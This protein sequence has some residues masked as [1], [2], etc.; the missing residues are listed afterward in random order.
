MKTMFKKTLLAVALAGVGASAQAAVV[1]QSLAAQDYSKQ[2]VAAKAADAAVTATFSVQLKA[3]YKNDDVIT[4]KFTS[5]TKTGWTAPASVIAVPDDALTDAVVTLGL[6][7]QTSDTLTYRVTDVNKSAGNTTIDNTITFTG[8]EFTAATLLSVTDIKVTYS[9]KTATGNFEIDTGKD[10]TAKILAAVDQFK[11]T[12]SSKFDALIELPARTSLKAAPAPTS[13]ATTFANDVALR[14]FATI[15]AVTYT[16]E[17]D[18][19]WIKDTSD[20]DVGLTPAPTLFTGL[21][22]QCT[23]TV[24]TST[25]SKLVF[26]CTAGTPLSFTFNIAANTA[27]VGQPASTAT[28]ATVAQTLKSTKYALTARVAY[29]TPT[30]AFN[31]LSAADAGEWKV[32]GVYVDVPYLLAGTVGEKEFSYVVNVTNNHSLSGNVTLDVYKEDGSVVAT[33]VAAGS[34]APNAIKRLGTDI[35]VKDN[36]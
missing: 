34:V 26:S 20:A 16:L 12:I 31:T 10:N 18:F 7:S 24:A 6:L 9:A 22:A 30:G 32:D 29:T 8:V 35:K 4:I 2:A 13:I 23:N 33:R 25:T 14:E 15:G 28:A 1:T 21:P 17:G 27:A 3:E 19:S 36:K 11:S 5:P